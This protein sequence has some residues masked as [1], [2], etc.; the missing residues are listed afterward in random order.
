M[1]DLGTE[2]SSGTDTSTWTKAMLVSTKRLPFGDV[3]ALPP[4]RRFAV[5]VGVAFAV[6]SLCAIIRPLFSPLSEKSHR[7]VRQK[8][9]YWPIHQKCMS[10]AISTLPSAVPPFASTLYLFY[11]S[12]FLAYSTIKNFPF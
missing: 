7:L 5:D 10:V 12:P 9:C 1:L 8:E 6:F 4:D 2:T 11:S 3:Y